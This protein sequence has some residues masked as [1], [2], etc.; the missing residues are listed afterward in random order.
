MKLRVLD[1][2][3]KSEEQKCIETI[4]VHRAC[5]SHV[6]YVSCFICS[7][8]S[9]LDRT[10]N[11]AMLNVDRR[12]R[13][14]SDAFTCLDVAHYMRALP[15]GDIL[16][17]YEEGAAWIAERK[18]ASDLAN[19]LSSGR[20]FE[21]TARLHEA[22]YD[23]IFW[24]VE[25]SLEGHT[26]SPESLWGACINMTLRDKSFLVRTLDVNETAFVVKQLIKKCRAQPGIPNGLQMPAPLTKRKRDADKNLVFL[27]Q[28]MCLPSVSEGVAKKLQ[29]H[30][31]SLPAL[32]EALIDIDTFP[33]VRLNENS[34]IGRTRLRKLREYLCE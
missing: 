31:G 2:R 29:E 27:R 4:V 14:L 12:E 13:A 7:A 32:Q 20:L 9:S 28:L 11:R 15:V 34:C 16:C 33:S 3:H 18:K 21:Q 22:N 30:F 17:E 6:P 23:K 1:R 25:G 5:C 26:I 8:F 10:A 19:S 24:F